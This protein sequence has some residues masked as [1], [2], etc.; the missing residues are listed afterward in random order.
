MRRSIALIYAATIVVT[1]VPPAL[2]A[3]SK[4]ATTSVPTIN[5]TS[6]L[7]YLDVTVL[8]KRGRPVDR[9][10]TKDDFT[11]TDDKIP[12]TIFSF[13]SPEAHRA[14]A[15]AENETPTGTSPGPFW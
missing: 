6:S 10:L 11:I 1:T 5:V 15:G 14:P 4:P 9:G 3:Q 8:D 12:Q 7:V 13:E 2:N